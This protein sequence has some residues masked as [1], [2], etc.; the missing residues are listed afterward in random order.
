MNSNY[1]TNGED[2]ERGNSYW[3]RGVGRTKF[4]RDMTFKIIPFC[5]FSLVLFS[6]GAVLASTLAFNR[7]V[8]RRGTLVVSVLLL[9]FFG[10][11]GI[12]FM[13]LY[14][15]QLRLHARC[16]SQYGPFR[17]TS[18]PGTNSKYV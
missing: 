3:R 4:V 1:N 8:P 7:P 16:Q 5:C 11:F 15:R 13:Y 2:L 14:L 17:Y 12:G 6:I 18:G 9:V 10:F